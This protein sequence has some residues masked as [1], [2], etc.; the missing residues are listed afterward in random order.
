MN[1]TKTIARF[2]FDE[3]EITLTTIKA[4][5]CERLFHMAEHVI[6][7]MKSV[8]EWWSDTPQDIIHAHED[9][10]KAITSEDVSK[11]YKNFV[12]KMEAITVPSNGTN[13]SD[14]GDAMLLSVGTALQAFRD[15][16]HAW[17]V[18]N[19]GH[20]QIKRFLD[21]QRPFAQA[22]Y[23]IIKKQWI[24]KNCSGTLPTP[25]PTD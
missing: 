23:D 11:V 5:D 4:A 3:N 19:A 25:P 14:A 24:D 2:K 10:H 16:L 22:W 17:D 8:V 20:G 15:D 12:S 13:R 6:W 7:T 21:A 1:L 9:V 18:V